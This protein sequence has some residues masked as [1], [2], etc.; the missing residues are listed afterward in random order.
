[1]LLVSIRPWGW[2]CPTSTGAM[3]SLSCSF[4]LLNYPPPPPNCELQ[5]ILLATQATPQ[6]P[7]SL[8]GAKTLGAHVW[9]GPVSPSLSQQ[10][11][12]AP[13][14]MRIKEALGSGLVSSSCH[15][16]GRLSHPTIRM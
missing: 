13:G 10:L 14:L 11:R 5:N 2:E 16:P 7:A 15:T 4:L 6:M 9:P 8:E 1:M 3:R 12:E